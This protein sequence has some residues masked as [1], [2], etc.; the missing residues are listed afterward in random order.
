M[1]T[2]RQKIWRRWQHQYLVGLAFAPVYG[3]ALAGGALAWWRIA[4]RQSGFPVQPGHWLL[5]LTAW[6]SLGLSVM[7]V[8]KPR[9]FDNAPDFTA[10]L[11]MTIVTTVASRRMREP[12]H[13]RASFFGLAAGFGMAAA[14]C[15]FEPHVPPGSLIGGVGWLIVCLY[16]VAVFLG[17]FIDLAEGKRYDILHWCG[18]ATLFGLVGHFLAIMCV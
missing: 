3:M 18:I 6:F 13:W 7:Q 4:K 11:V 2:E 16:P 12:V 17:V 14:S 1:D 10:T 15:L 5:I 9:L 8:G